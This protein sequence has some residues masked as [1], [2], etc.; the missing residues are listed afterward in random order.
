MSVCAH[1]PHRLET[2]QSQ[3]NFQLNTHGGDNVGTL[4]TWKFDQEAIRK[5]ISHMLIVD[6]LPLKFIE[7][8]GFRHLMSVACPRF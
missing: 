4:S 8:E 5:A 6:E 7:G 2:R 3:L 1:H